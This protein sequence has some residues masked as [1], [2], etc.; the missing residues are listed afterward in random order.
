MI[1]YDAVNPMNAFMQTAGGLQILQDNN[2]AM[3]QKYDQQAAAQQAQKKAQDPI[4]QLKQQEMQIKQ[5]V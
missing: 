2:M 1:N 5:Q 3:Q 4:I